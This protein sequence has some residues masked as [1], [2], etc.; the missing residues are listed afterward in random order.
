MKYKRILLKLSGEAL[1]GDQNHG[2]D[3]IR[4]NHY[5]TEI[6]KLKEIGT[7]EYK[8]PAERDFTVKEVTMKELRHSSE[9]IHNAFGDVGIDRDLATFRYSE[10]AINQ[11]TGQKYADPFPPVM[12][13]KEMQKRKIANKPNQNS[14][15][16]KTKNINNKCPLLNL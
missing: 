3:P 2:I 7:V 1:M 5:A 8:L 14:N 15:Q 13:A 11:T 12:K 10:N 4:L 16:A 9:Q 6:K